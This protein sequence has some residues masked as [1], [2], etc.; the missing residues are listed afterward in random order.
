MVQSWN[1]N[2]NN[3]ITNMQLTKTSPYGQQVRQLLLTE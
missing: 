1:M 2:D 3:D